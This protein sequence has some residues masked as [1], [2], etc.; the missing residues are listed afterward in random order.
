MDYGV[1]T[2]KAAYYGYVW[3]RVCRPKSVSAGLDCG[4]GCAPT[5]SVTLRAVEAAYAA[6]S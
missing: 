5:L 1:E 6:C 2:I 3:L 4:L